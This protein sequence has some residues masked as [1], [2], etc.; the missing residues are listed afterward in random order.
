MTRKVCVLLL[1]MFVALALASGPVLAKETAKQAKEK[2]LKAAQYL[3]QKGTA[4]L[5]E[6]ND[7]K[8]AW[9]QEPY[10]FVY[11]FKGNII[12]HPNN[13]LIGKNFLALK[14]VKGNMFPAEFVAIAK[15]PG[16]GWSEYW[17]PKP[18]EKKPSQ[19]VSYIVRVP[20]KEMF[21]GTGIY[22]YSKDQAIK[23]AGK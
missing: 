21:V 10:V 6:F 17:W 22:D 1:A 12:A 8:N 3:G 18:G 16:K 14:D 23:E 7:S 2:A 4:A 5:P 19:K 15:G 11:D 13:K 9:G 20:G